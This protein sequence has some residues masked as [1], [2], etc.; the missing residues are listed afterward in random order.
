[1][2][3]SYSTFLS[4]AS[5]SLSAFSLGPTTFLT[6]ANFS[7]ATTQTKSVVAAT[8]TFYIFSFVKSGLLR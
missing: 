6:Y 2:A 7:V 8:D 3:N 4:D 1:M 5:A